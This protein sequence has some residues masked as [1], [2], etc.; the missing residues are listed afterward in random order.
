MKRRS[1][2][3]QLV[4]IS[5]HA[6]QAAEGIF[7][8]L[9]TQISLRL[10]MWMWIRFK[11]ATKAAINRQTKLSGRGSYHMVSLLRKRIGLRNGSLRLDQCGL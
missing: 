8:P 1:S 3:K 6:L 5:T 4:R 11:T 10:W 7:G 9:D 2:A